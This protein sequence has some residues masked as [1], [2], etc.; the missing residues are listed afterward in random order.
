MSGL[1]G[2]PLWC[3]L[4]GRPYAAEWFATT[5]DVYLLLGLTLKEAPGKFKATADAAGLATPRNAYARSSRGC[6][7]A[8]MLEIFVRR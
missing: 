6:Q 8:P 5:Q 4:L 2:T 1:V 7:R 3:A